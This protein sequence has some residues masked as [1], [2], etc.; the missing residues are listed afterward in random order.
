MTGERGREHGK[1]FSTFYFGVSHCA[2]SIRNENCQ[3]D[4]LNGITTS[5]ENVWVQYGVSPDNN[6][7]L[8]QDLVGAK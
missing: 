3:A 1:A 5:G 2:L 7:S 6:L 8:L 4:L